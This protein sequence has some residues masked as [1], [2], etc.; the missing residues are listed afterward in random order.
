MGGD[1][2]RAIRRAVDGDFAAGAATDGADGF[3]LGWAKTVGFALF[4]DWTRHYGLPEYSAIKQNTL[5]R[6][7]IK[8]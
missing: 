8:A 4:A 1:E 6:D 7:R 2:V 5:A 3:A